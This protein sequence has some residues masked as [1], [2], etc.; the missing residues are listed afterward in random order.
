MSSPA[1]KERQ[2]VRVPARHGK[3]VT[4]VGTRSNGQ[5]QGSRSL[6]GF[7]GCG[8][9]VNA[10]ALEWFSQGQ[11]GLSESRRGS[12]GRC[13]GALLP[14]QHRERAVADWLS[15][16]CEAARRQ[17]AQHHAD[18]LTAVTITR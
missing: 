16:L 10:A 5:R 2:G 6:D 4:Q 17:R 8:S 3:R 14:E 18:G 12:S 9:A 11:L 7:S 13:W 1:I 15:C